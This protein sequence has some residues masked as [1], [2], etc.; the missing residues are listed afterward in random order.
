MAIGIS[1]V[2]IG[3]R[4]RSADAACGAEEGKRACAC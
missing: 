1:E 3:E 4:N 2:A